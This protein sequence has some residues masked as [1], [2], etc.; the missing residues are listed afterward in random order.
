MKN[1]VRLRIDAGAVSE[2]SGAGPLNSDAPTS[3]TRGAQAE[4]LLRRHNEALVSYIY[5]WVRCRA[6][7]HDIAQEAYVEVLGLS[8]SHIASHVRRRLYQTARRMAANA[9]RARI[10]RE[11]RVEEV[12]LR[13][14]QDNQ[15]TAEQMR[16]EYEA[17]KRAFRLLSP[18]MRMVIHL[19]KEDNM[20][21]EQVA[22]TM[23]IQRETVERLVERAMEYLLE[24][25]HREKAGRR[26]T[27]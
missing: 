11:T 14:S 15:L 2:G 17:V 19:I 3:D 9:V 20:S 5:R 25:V 13:A 18:K 23:G 22:A 12:P 24:V 10:V 6:E 21:Y 26:V 16:I 27:W 4:R 1:D 7:A 8:D